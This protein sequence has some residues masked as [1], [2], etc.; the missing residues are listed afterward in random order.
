MQILPLTSTQEG[1]VF[2]GGREGMFVVGKD[3]VVD[4]KLNLTSDVLVLKTGR[5]SFQNSFG[6]IK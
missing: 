6:D 4:R 1:L 3:K 5:I 2:S